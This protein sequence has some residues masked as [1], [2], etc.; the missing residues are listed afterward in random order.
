MPWLS[1]M[2]PRCYRCGRPREEGERFSRRG[3]CVEC[4]DG[5]MIRNVRELKRHDGPRFLRW[6]RGVAAS[7]GAILLDE[8]QTDEQE[9]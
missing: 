6:R 4:G 8:L 9:A 7:V 1:D 5:E 2:A 3:R